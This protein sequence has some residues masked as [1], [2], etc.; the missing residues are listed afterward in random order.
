MARLSRAPRLGYALAFLVL[1]AAEVVLALFVR[2]R[3]FR[4]YV[5]DVLAV[6]A[7]YCFLRILLP[8]GLPW[9]PAGVVLFA[10]LVE[11]G[12]GL[13]LAGHL[14]LDQIPF[15]HILLGSVFDWADLLCYI[16]GGALILLAEGLRTRLSE[17]RKCFH[18]PH[19]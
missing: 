4:P 14:G 17:K 12:Q 6:P 10:G 9:L 5:G 3:F 16:I 15:F 1:L 18:A 13:Q 2:D 19:R 11:V 7:V 8:Q